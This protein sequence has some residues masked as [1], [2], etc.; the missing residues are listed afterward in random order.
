MRI[1]YGLNRRE[2]SFASANIER[3]KFFIDTDN[4][5]Q[6]EREAM[7][8]C[9]R[10]G[11]TVVVMAKKDLGTG[12]GQVSIIKAIEAAGGTVEVLEGVKDAPPPLSETEMNAAQEAEICRIWGNKALSEATRLIRIA[13]CLGKPMEKAQVYYLCVTKPKRK[14]A[15]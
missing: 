8:H 13:E 6:L 3:G 15:K 5:K 14:K 7:L 11:V 10:P 1:A 9:V 12:A 4:T 2:K